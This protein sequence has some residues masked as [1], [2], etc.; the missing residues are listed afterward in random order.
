[1]Q[2]N[3][4]NDNFTLEPT[5]FFLLF[6]SIFW[7][8][9]SPVPQT[10]NLSKKFLFFQ[11]CNSPVFDTTLWRLVFWL[12]HGHSP[13]TVGLTKCHCKWWS[14]GCRISCGNLVNLALL[15][16]WHF[17]TITYLEYKNVPTPTTLISNVKFINFIG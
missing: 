13:R 15:N 8:E 16:S 14:L 6:P 1:M 9:K 4:F 3:S 2:N 10:W 11:W 12:G 5:Y 17:L 7:S